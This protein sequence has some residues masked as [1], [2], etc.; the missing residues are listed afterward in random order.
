VDGSSLYTVVTQPLSGRARVVTG[1]P[2]E[3]LR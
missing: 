1:R 2:P 3:S